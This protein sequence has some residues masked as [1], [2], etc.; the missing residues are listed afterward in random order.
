[1][2]GRID[3]LCPQAL[4]ILDIGWVDL[5]KVLLKLTFGTE[6]VHCSCNNSKCPDEFV[7]QVYTDVS[8]TQ[9]GQRHV[10][11]AAYVRAT[12]LL[13]IDACGQGQKLR[14]SVHTCKK[15]HGSSKEGIVLQLLFLRTLKRKKQ[16]SK[17]LSL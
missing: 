1:L 4:R 17:F 15:L 12:L 13:Q 14:G 8:M 6:N 2:R 5:A 11:L 10:G 3:L 9:A 16:H 7:S